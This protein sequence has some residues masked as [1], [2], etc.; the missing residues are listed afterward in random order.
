[1][2]RNR[3]YRYKVMFSG[4][5]P[6]DML[7]HDCAYPRDTEDAQTIARSHNPDHVHNDR[8]EGRGVYTVTLV[9]L[10]TPTCDRWASF[11]PVSVVRDT[12]E[13]L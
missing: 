7:R 11:G 2:N 13:R 12:I 9:G 8:V 3:L 5:F 10:I 6:M 4:P 1:M